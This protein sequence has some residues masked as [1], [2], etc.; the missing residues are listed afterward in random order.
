MSMVILN[1]YVYVYAFQ[2]FECV[3]C[4]LA[5]FFESSVSAGASLLHSCLYLFDHIYFRSVGDEDLDH[6]NTMSILVG[7]YCMSILPNVSKKDQQTNR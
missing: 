3:T 7:R 4:S 2:K 1:T 6:E 5:G